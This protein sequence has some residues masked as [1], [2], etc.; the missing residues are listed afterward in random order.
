MR[1]RTIALAAVFLLV[2]FDT[3][4]Q[5]PPA[6]SEAVKALVGT[7][8]ISN[9]D[10]DKSCNVTFR[11]DAVA[12]GMRVELDKACAGAFPT[13]KDVAVWSLAPNDSIQLLDAKGKSVIEFS[14]VESGL[15]EG[16]RPGD[17]LYFLQSLAA[18]SGERTADQMFGDWNFT[19]GTAKAVCA[20]TLSNTASG[21]DAYRLA[22]KPGC[23]AAVTRFAPVTW[24]MERGQLVLLSAK[25]EAWRFEEA[26]TI[27]WR[28]IPEARPPMVLVRQ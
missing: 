21:D 8:E 28:R 4:G 9:S 6:P 24:K 22:L 16:L 15:Y 14:E 10:R 3:K 25:G 23:D 7:W 17:P 26:D 2:G 19:R 5:T 18:A 1:L 11:A 12:G 20:A 13:L 27:T